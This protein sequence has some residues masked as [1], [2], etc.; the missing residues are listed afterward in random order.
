MDAIV[1]TL[2]IWAPFAVKRTGTA[3]AGATPMFRTVAVIVVWSR[4]VVNAIPPGST[5]R[6]GS[7]RCH[8]SAF[9]SS[10]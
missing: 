4:P 5:E 6:S 9:W 10:W 1:C 7:G 3:L 2:P 8:W